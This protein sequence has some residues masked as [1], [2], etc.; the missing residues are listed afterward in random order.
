VDA[1]PAPVAPMLAV[2]GPLPVGGGWAFETKWDFCTR[3][4]PVGQRDLVQAPYRNLRDITRSYPKHVRAPT[5]LLTG[6]SSS[7]CSIS[8]RPPTICW[9]ARRS[10]SIGTRRGRRQVPASPGGQGIGNYSPGAAG[11][12]RPVHWRPDLPPQRL[13]EGSTPI[14]LMARRYRVCARCASPWR[15]AASSSRI[16]SRWGCSS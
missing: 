7:T 10:R 8:C 9:S 2:E 6:Q 14:S 3:F 11:L 13:C 12:E 16:R 4:R 1:A 15:P 5:A